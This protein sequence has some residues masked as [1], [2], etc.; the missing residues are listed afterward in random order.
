MASSVA[1]RSQRLAQAN[2]LMSEHGMAEDKRSIYR[3][4]PEFGDT[5]RGSKIAEMVSNGSE[6]WS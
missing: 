4:L 6:I 2:V 3:R 5:L 1:Q